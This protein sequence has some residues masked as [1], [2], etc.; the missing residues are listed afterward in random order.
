[1]KLRTEF[2][3]YL[4]PIPEDLKPIMQWK[5]D[6]S[7]SK[8]PKYASFSNGNLTIK[9]MAGA[10]RVSCYN[11]PVIGT[12]P[13]SV[14]TVQIVTNGHYLIGFCPIDQ[15]VQNGT[16]KARDSCLFQSSTGKVWKY[17]NKAKPYSSA[18]H[19]NDKIT[20]IKCGS[21]I[22]FLV[23]GIDQGEAVNNA[24]DEMYPIVELFDVGS[25]VMIV[26]N[27]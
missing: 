6:L 14:F 18:L 26:P 8:K 27:P 19:V 25:S 7:A 15:F 2:D 24:P 9:K 11:C 10:V 5:F 3:Y 13:V 1:M 22:R 20:G 12:S 23:N 17:P 16:D 21:S 4:L